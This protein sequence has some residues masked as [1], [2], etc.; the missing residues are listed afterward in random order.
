MCY[1]QKKKKKKKHSQSSVSADHRVKMRESEKVN[2]Y[3]DLARELKKLW[4]MRVTVI[5]IVI[6]ALGMVPKCSEE[7]LDELK[8]RG[9]IETIKTTALLRSAKI[10]RKVMGTCCHLDSCKRP[11]ADAA[12][13]ILISNNNNNNN[14]NNN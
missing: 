10:L 12:V 5:P 8:F 6:G 4:N 11:S 2:R 1:W 7:R 9:R 14:N 13:K 3:L